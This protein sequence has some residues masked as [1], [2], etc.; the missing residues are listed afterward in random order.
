MENKLIHRTMLN[1]V[2]EYTKMFSVL[3][4]TGSRQVGKTTLLKLYNDKINFVSLDDLKE[5]ELAIEDPEMFLK[6]H[7]YPLIIDE[8]QYAPNLLSY[9]KIIVD[10]EK[11][12][13][14]KA[15]KN[16]E[17][18]YYLTGS[19]VFSAMENV[20][21]TLAGRIGII[22]MYGL[23][24]KEIHN[25]KNDLFVPTLENIK[26]T[27]RIENFDINNV[28]ERIIKGSYPKLYQ[29]DNMK[30][31]DCYSSYVATYI[32]R[33]IRKLININNEGKFFKF[34]T[35]LAVRSGSILN[36]ND[37]ASASEVSSATCE[38]WLSILNNTGV[39]YILKPYFSNIEKRLIKAPKVYFMDTGLACYLTGYDDAFIL[40]K[41]AYNVNIFE[42]Y[43]ISEIVKNLSNNAINVN[44]KLFYY[45]DSNKVEVDLF[46]IENNEIFPIEIKMSS[47]PGKG[48]VKNINSLRNLNI[49]LKD[50]LVICMANEIFP[51]DDK[52][53]LVPVDYI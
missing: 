23:T 39:I 35:A 3:L 40:S 20:S 51:V 8:F 37:L 28:F 53:Y 22:N 41:S 38:N 31:K 25:K 18:L 29:N 48:G 14:L 5:R 46:I 12:K 16:N 49:N 4:L 50:G 1:I 32:E 47:N 6:I 19:Q 10:E 2:E 24:T 21:E 52:N 30:I 42:T 7:G 27:E 13:N 43:V 11:F 9:I 33:D 17:V 36:L 44:Q 26:T 15:N 45:R 34:I